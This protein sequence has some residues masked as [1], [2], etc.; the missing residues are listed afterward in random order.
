MRIKYFHI[1][2]V[3]MQFSDTVTY[4]RLPCQ[5][6]AAFYL[7]LVIY[8]PVQGKK[9]GLNYHTLHHLVLILLHTPRIS[10]LNVQLLS[11]LVE[12]PLNESGLKFSESKTSVSA[13]SMKVQ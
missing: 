8:I 6:A 2:F 1:T 12:P 10:S 7:T 5:L 4:N 13:V 3:A 11:I 9:T